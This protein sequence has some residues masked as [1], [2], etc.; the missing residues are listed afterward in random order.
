MNHE[1]YEEALVSLATLHADGNTQDDY[2]VAEFDL[3]KEQIIEEHSLPPRSY[4]SLFK[5]RKNFRRMV[6]IFF[7]QAG[8]QM[9]GVSALQ[10]FSP[11]IF[12]EI[13]ISTGMTLLFTAVSTMMGLIGTLGEMYLID[14]I[15]R[16]P[17]GIGGNAIQGVMFLIGAVLL[18]K[19]KSDTTATSAH[20][21]FI[22]T[23][24]LWN[25]CYLGSMAPLSWLI[26][27]E[28]L[29]VD[30]RIKGVSIGV[31]TSFAFNTMIGQITPTAI[32]NI[33][34]KYYILFIIGNFGNAL[35]FW[36]FYPETKGISLEEMEDLFE[37]SPIFVPTS[38]Y[39]YKH[40]L[41]KHYEQIRQK[42]T[43]TDMEV[44]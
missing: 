3:I 30:L 20:W 5:E 6:L 37:S 44:C 11:D 16:R 4:W 8:C 18:A 22:I 19:Y 35:F 31:M 36:A 38:K 25:L 39:E 2:V 14:T 29:P 41:D 12:L 42:Q 40:T 21:G 10:Y 24:W 7:V 33:G 23:T 27:P 34:W 32:K 1:R 17:L 43:I 26:P 9:T 13:G 28:L 15:G